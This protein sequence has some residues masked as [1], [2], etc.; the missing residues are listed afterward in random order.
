M[1][2]IA[3]YGAMI[4]DHGR[5]D[6]FARALGQAVKPGAVVVDIGTGTGIFALLACRFGA[7]RVYA[8]EPSDAIQVAREIAAANG[9]ADRI[10]FIQAMSNQVTLSE[11]ADVIIS[12]LVGVLPW[13][14]RHIPS[15]ADAR[16]RFLAPGG[17]MIPQRDVAWAA[18][19]DM[20]DSYAQQTCPWDAN[21]FGLD[22]DAARRLVI[23]TWN[24]ARVTRDNLLTELQRWATLDYSV[25]EE[26]AVRA[27]VTWTVTRPGTAHGLAAGFDRTVSDGV[28][29][30]NAPDA[31]DVIRPAQIYGT[32]FF[33]WPV[34]VT[35]AAGDVVTV[36][37]EAKLIRH[38]YIWSWKTRI[39]DRGQSGADKA[40]FTQSTFFGMPL[41]PATLQKRAAGHTPTLTEDGRIARFVLE[42]MDDG[43]PLGEIARLL[44]TAFSLRFPRP[45]DALSHVADLSQ[46]YG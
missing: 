36:D 5:M 21:G 41:S 16:R 32:V 43:V 13:F 33:P 44:S 27:R 31:P 15:I 7:R 30:S 35:L 37:L 29:L 24:K 17:T 10:E 11:R 2:S 6:A 18:V 39:L 1:Y 9:C 20:H 25:V 8:I 26:P 46:Q 45:K 3:D 42:S 23:N 14:E 28:D 38:D 22:M 40:N 19:V 34:P 12:D 4:A